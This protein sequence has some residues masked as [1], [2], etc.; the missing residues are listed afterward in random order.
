[1]RN[2]LGNESS[3]YLLQHANNPVDWFPWGEEAFLKAKAEDKPVFLSIG[4][5]ACHWCHVMAHEC[6]E[7]N[8][9]ASLMNDTFVN[10]KVD[11]EELP[12][13]DHIYMQACQVL[14]GS[15]G[16]PLT[17]VMTPDKEPFF[18]AT[19]LPKHS[20]SGLMGMMDLVGTLGN[21]WR[22]K[23]E[24][25]ISEA[26]EIT[27]MV[28]RSGVV[29][30]GPDMNPKLLDQAY[31]ELMSRFDPE[32]GGFGAA[33]KFP[34]PQTI[35]FLLR[36]HYRTKNEEALDMAVKTLHA[37]HAGG[38]YDHVGYGFHR[39]ATDDTWLV[40]H[41]EKMLYDQALLTM[42]YTEAFQVTG[43]VDFRRIAGEIISYVLRDLHTPEGLFAGAQDADSEGEEGKYYLWKTSEVRALLGDAE[44]ALAAQAFGLRENGNF[45]SD[46]PEGLNI[47][48]QGQDRAA[49]AVMHGTDSEIMAGRLQSILSILREARSHRIP[50]QKDTKALTDWNGLMIAG[51]AK[52]GAVFSTPE[53]IK[54][55]QKAADFILEKMMVE[56]RLSHVFVN[57]KADR[58]A[59]LDDYAFLI[60]GLIELYEA[61]FEEKYLA[62]AMNLAGI[63]VEHFWDSTEG[64]FFT[65][66][67]D[68]DVPIARTKTGYDNAI[69]SGNSVAMLDLLR[70]GG[71][72]GDQSYKARANMIGKTFS[73]QAN[74]IPTAFTFMLCGLGFMEGPAQE[75]VIAGEPSKDDTRCMIDALHRRFLPHAS[76]M[77]ASSTKD[78]DKHSP[79]QGKRPFKG[80]ATAYVCTGSSCLEPTTRSGK[81]SNLL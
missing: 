42:A 1:M 51:L 25:V 37:M 70:L 29:R 3:P 26:A 13:I 24:R 56:G 6:F 35:M 73:L 32:N 74:H 72:T 27:Q 34:M 33:P 77:L 14:T 65:A 81:C 75:V 4:Y 80:R 50:P 39:Y 41:F 5:S 22:D 28:R 30:P 62:S 31:E 76:I 60:W 67:D 18:A 47:I 21:I 66:A 79:V 19:Y 59:G 61:A 58:K 8:E 69:P 36:Y 64:G 49:L 12:H 44:Y 2:R 54:A 17:I 43:S 20:R 45:T 16:W 23:R 11:R 63:M 53:Y 40:P 38:M 46:P 52:A 68:T 15:G 9:V 7:D 48:I 71:L 78:R 55:A 10:V 57:G